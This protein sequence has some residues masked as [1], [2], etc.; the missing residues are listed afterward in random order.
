MFSFRGLTKALKVS[1]VSAATLYSFS[2]NQHLSTSHQYY[3]TV[4][5]GPQDKARPP[6]KQHL[7]VQ[8]SCLSSPQILSWPH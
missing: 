8:P 1:K 4:Q 5:V 2:S 6:L 3:V 7:Y